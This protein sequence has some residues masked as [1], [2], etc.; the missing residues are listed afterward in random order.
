VADT[1]MNRWIFLRHRGT[2]DQRILLRDNKTVR[3]LHHYLFTST[4][5]HSL[6]V[7]LALVEW[8]Y[9]FCE[10]QRSYLKTN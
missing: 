3:G 1:R 6:L 10:S 8:M 5:S 4:P 7:L 9:L 2:T